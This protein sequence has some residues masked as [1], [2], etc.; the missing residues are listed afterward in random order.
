M[1]MFTVQHDSSLKYRKKQF[2]SW[3]LIIELTQQV[4]KVISYCEHNSTILL[5]TVIL[6]IY[7]FLG[8]VNVWNCKCS[9][10]QN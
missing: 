6:L 8:N 4:K 3:T 9:K 1:V 2:Y 10:L 5:I 7:T